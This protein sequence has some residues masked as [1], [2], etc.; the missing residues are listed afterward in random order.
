MV[1]LVQD[2]DTQWWVLELGIIQYDQLT[3]W[4]FQPI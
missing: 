1:Q 2:Q 4:W 3:S